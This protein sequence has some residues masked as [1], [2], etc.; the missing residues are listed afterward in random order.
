MSFTLCFKLYIKPFGASYL[1]LFT[2]FSSQSIVHLK[3]LVA[4]IQRAGLEAKFPSPVGISFKA[5]TILSYHSEISL[6]HIF[7]PLAFEQLVPVGILPR[8]ELNR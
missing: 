1:K 6:D 7:L 3:V 4:L 2:V 5:A 8:F